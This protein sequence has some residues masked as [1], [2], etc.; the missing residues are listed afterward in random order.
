MKKNLKLTV[1]M[2]VLCA[3]SALNVKVVLDTDHSSDLAM[4]SLAA[5]S[6]SRSGEG[7]SGEGGSDKG[8]ISLDCTTITTDVYTQEANCMVCGLKHVVSEWE[9][10]NCN[11]GVFSFCYPGYIVTYYDCER[12]PESV[13]D[14][15]DI[16]TCSIF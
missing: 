7:S 11:R 10:R 15:T 1:F 3:V 9:T 12:N 16:S 2:V 5:I 6:Q 8:D 14:N 4:T 13:T